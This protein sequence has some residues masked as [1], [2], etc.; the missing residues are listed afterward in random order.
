MQIDI[1]V[2]KV[3]CLTRDETGWG[4]MDGEGWGE[5]NERG[6]SG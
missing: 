1:C 5:K 6:M 3:K 2:L 4:G